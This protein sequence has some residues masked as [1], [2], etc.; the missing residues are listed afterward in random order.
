MKVTTYLQCTNNWYALNVTFVYEYS[1]YNVIS[2]V[3]EPSD[4][5]FSTKYHIKL[6][7]YATHSL[8]RKTMADS[9]L[10]INLPAPKICCTTNDTD[11]D[12]L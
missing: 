5:I 4:A 3:G 8:S 11:S 12:S 6:R 10:L 2:D 7:G 1:T 9:N